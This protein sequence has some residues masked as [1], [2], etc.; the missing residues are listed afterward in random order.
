MIAVENE[1]VKRLDDG[2]IIQIPAGHVWVEC[3]CLKSK[4]RNLDSLTDFGP[5]SQ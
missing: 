1:W 2:G 3:E 5:I 4:N